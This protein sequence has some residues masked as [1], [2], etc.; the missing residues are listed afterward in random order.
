MNGNCVKSVGKQ[1]SGPLEFNHRYGIIISPITGH[2]YI[3]DIG[4]DRIQVLNPDL[5]FSHTFGT[6]GSANNNLM[7]ITECGNDYIFIFTTD[8]QFVRSFGGRG[9]SVGQFNFPYGITFDRKR[10]LYVCD[11]WNNRLVVY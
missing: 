6:K 5:T 4:N 11:Y 1:G 7:Y 3:A 10:Y 9:S 2:I 8:G